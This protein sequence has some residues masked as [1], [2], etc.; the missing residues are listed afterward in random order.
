MWQIYL[1]SKIL[2]QFVNLVIAVLAYRLYY[3]LKDKRSLFL[4]AAFMVLF[5]YNLTSLFQ[6]N[7]KLKIEIFNFD[8]LE[9]ISKF[10]FVIFVLLLIFALMNPKSFYEKAFLIYL[11]IL[12][13]YTSIFHQLTSVFI[14]SVFLALLIVS[15]S[16]FIN[17]LNNPKIPKLFL[18]GG[19][20]LLAISFAFRF[21]NDIIY[22][23]FDVLSLLSFFIYLV[24]LWTGIWISGEK[25]EELIHEKKDQ[26]SIKIGKSRI[27]KSLRRILRRKINKENK[28][29]EKSSEINIHEI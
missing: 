13:V 17:Y 10:F 22:Q 1:L 3:F 28:E 8:V 16:I 27:N 18:F 12:S 29:K 5:I 7:E 25:K 23:I 11:I 15:S 21:F 4:S 14:L 9:F 6:L 26:E 19:I 20:F 24:L 2:L